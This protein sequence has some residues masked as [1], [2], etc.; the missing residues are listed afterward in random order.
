MGSFFRPREEDQDLSG[1]A[2]VRHI[3]QTLFVIS[4]FVALLLIT[5]QT[6]SGTPVIMQNIQIRIYTASKIQ[7]ISDSLFVMLKRIEV[8]TWM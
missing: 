2:Q 4:N 6:S 7:I 5:F 3:H 8:P 1:Y